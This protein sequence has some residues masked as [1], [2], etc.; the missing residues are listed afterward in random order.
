MMTNMKQMIVVHKY[1]DYVDA[2]LV[3][4]SECAR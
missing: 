2:V 4:L 1:A 3:M